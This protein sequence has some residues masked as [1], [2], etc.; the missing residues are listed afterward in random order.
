MNFVGVFDIRVCGALA[1]SEEGF[2]YQLEDRAAIFGDYFQPG[3]AA[4]HGEI[5]AAETEA[6]QGASLSAWG[7]D[8]WNRNSK[9]LASQ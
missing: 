9:H 8:G 4:H 2:L 1:A 3:E 5:D 7:P 6:G